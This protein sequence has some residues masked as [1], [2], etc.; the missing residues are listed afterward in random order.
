MELNVKVKDGPYEIPFP[1][2][3]DIAEKNLNNFSNALK[4][5]MSLH[6]KPLGDPTLN[7]ALTNTFQELLAEDWL[8]HVEKIKVDGFIWHLPF[9]GTKQEKSRVVYDGAATF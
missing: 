9:F 6:R 1:L 7:Q 8:T 4:R 2:R 5:T 3:P